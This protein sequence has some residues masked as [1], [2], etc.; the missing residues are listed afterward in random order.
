MSIKVVDEVVNSITS[1]RVVL[2][3]QGIMRTMAIGNDWTK[4]RVGMVLNT[5][6]S[7]GITGTPRLYFGLLQGTSGGVLSNTTTDFLGVRTADTDFGTSPLH[8][9]RSWDYIR[10]TGSSTT[11]VSNQTP[12]AELASVDAAEDYS[13]CIVL[14]FEKV[15]GTTMGLDIWTQYVIANH[16]HVTAEKLVEVCN[17]DAAPAGI[18]G[19]G[20]NYTKSSF[21]NAG[22]I[23]VSVYDSIEIATNF[24]RDFQVD[25]VAYGRLA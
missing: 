17:T 4:L 11:L 24:L 2:F 12:A 7:T 16:A 19:S 18:I 8:D 20:A 22:S 13:N 9:C 3:A 23:D 5:T 21:S 10:K 14:D 15:N 25:A 6:G 1:R